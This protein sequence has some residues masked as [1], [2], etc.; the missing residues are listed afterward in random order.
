MK[1]KITIDQL[2]RKFDLISCPLTRNPPISKNKD[3]YSIRVL[4]SH[5]QDWS[6]NQHF[7]MD[8]FRT[9]IEGL[10]I[11]SPR[12]MAKEYNN[13]VIIIGLDKEL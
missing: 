12:G 11:E 13:K 8:Y 3:G 5:K 10:V 7:K 9:D 2:K 6:G 1:R 4:K